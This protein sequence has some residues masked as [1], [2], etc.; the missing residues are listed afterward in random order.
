MEP[1][2]S[3]VTSREREVCLPFY[4]Q[5]HFL[6]PKAELLRHHSCCRALR[7]PPPATRC[8]LSTS[9]GAGSAARGLPALQ[10]PGPETQRPEAIFSPSS[11]NGSLPSFLK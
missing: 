8:P 6:L 11:G 5:E 3:Y 10:A 4:S 2:L 1:T 9:A 7:L